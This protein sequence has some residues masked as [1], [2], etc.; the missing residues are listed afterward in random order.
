MF[1]QIIIANTN[2]SQYSGSI[3]EFLIVQN[4][5]T[6]RQEALAVERLCVFHILAIF[7][8]FYITD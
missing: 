1:Q 6:K 8:F 2:I 3:F 7:F 4:F 5:G